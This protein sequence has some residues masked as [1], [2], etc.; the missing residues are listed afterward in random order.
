MEKRVDILEAV[1]GTPKTES[2]STVTVQ[3]SDDKLI[4]RLRRQTNRKPRSKGKSRAK[5][6]AVVKQSLPKAWFDE[7]VSSLFFACFHRD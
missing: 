6:T 2:A 1:L 7:Q 5:N 4:A 3:T